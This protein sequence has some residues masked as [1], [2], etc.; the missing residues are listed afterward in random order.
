MALRHFLTL[1]DLSSIELQAIID[2]AIELKAMQRNGTLYQPFVGK[3]LGMIFEKSST[4]TRVS[5]ESGMAN[6]LKIRHGLFPACW[7]S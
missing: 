6:P 7:I 1:T 5:F 4:R 3:V 2:R